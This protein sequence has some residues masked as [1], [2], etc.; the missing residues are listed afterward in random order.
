ME[1]DDFFSF[2]SANSSREGACRPLNRH[3]PRKHRCFRVAERPGVESV[4]HRAAPWTKASS[5]RVLV[6][7]PAGAVVDLEVTRPPELWDRHKPRPVLDRDTR[8][9]RIAARLPPTGS[10]V[11]GRAVVMSWREERVPSDGSRKLSVR[12][13]PELAYGTLGDRSCDQ[14]RTPAQPLCG[15]LVADDAWAGHRH[16]CGLLHPGSTLRPDAHRPVAGVAK[17]HRHVV[18]YEVWRRRPRSAAA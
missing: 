17:R 9:L 11:A 5:A 14:S 18:A 7:L 16:G 4:V 8:G 2:D 3:D 10:C 13:D 6:K 12:L 1:N 15:R